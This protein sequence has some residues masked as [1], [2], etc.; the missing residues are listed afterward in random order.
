MPLQSFVLKTLN[1]VHFNPFKKRPELQTNCKSYIGSGLS[2]HS[3]WKSHKKSHINIFLFWHFPPFFVLLKLS[4]NTVWP[5]CTPRN[6]V[7]C[8]FFCN[9]K[10]CECK[11]QAIALIFP[12]FSCVPEM[13]LTAFKPLF[14]R[15]RL[16][17]VSQ[18]CSNRNASKEKKVNK[19]KG[20][21]HP[22]SRTSYI[23]TTIY[24]SSWQF[25][26]LFWEG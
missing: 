26:K 10:H 16:A 17:F 12:G 7:K 4:G 23:E 24:W 11:Y 15:S 21:S 22:S 9:F 18:P 8:D 14:H 13:E 19:G 1:Q 6:V 20:F 5:F 3:V 25:Q 2:V